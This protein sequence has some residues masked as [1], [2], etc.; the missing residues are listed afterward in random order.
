M[1]GTIE[2]L[3]RQWLAAERDATDR[4]NSGG[5]EDRARLSSVVYENALAAAS[6][7]DL[8]V[9]WH[10]AARKAQHNCE[11]GSASLRP[12]MTTGRFDRYVT[13]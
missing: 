5:W 12:V 8:L 2:E 7:A 13:R 3:A 1:S 9:A 11:M 10:V 6:R 4:G